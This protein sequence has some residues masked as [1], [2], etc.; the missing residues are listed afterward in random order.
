MCMLRILLQ[1]AWHGK[2][3]LQDYEMANYWDTKFPMNLFGINSP[4]IRSRQALESESQQQ[5]Q[6]FHSRRL[7]VARR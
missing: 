5:Q 6:Q 7:M 1:E 3:K 4:D 2:G